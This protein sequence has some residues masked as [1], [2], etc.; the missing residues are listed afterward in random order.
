MDTGGAGRAAQYIEPMLRRC[1]E[2]IA[3]AT[4]ARCEV[5]HAWPAR[6]L[7][8]SC[9]DRFGARAN[10]CRTCA[11]ALPEGVAQCG[12]CLREPPPLAACHAAVS[13]GYPWSGLISRYKFHGLPGW[14]AALADLLHAHPG[15]AAEI[16]GADHVLPMPLAAG[17]LRERGFNQAWELARRLAP[18][19]ARPG[20]VL[21][22]RETAAQSRLDRDERLRNLRHAFAVEPS[23]ADRLRGASIVL[24]D[25]VMT[26]GASLF[27]LAA[28]LQQAGAAR[29]AGVVLARTE[30]TEH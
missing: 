24:V 28:T 12:R 6:P 29:V 21:R 23:Q 25:D 30:D 20:M 7:C 22:L 9:T 18:A 4:P 13:Y 15:A 26:S 3:A 8:D 10:R 17:R 2:G 1:L 27:A 14:A 11:L 16:R 19:T 5:C